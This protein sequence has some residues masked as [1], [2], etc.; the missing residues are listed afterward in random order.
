MRFWKLQSI[1]NDFP[2]IHIADAGTLDLG[3]VAIKICD[4]RFGAGGDGLLAVAMEDGDVRLRMFNP[5]G[6]E[7]FCGNGLR[8]AARHVVDQGWVGTT[9]N[10]RHLDRVVPTTVDGSRISTTIGKASYKPEDVPHLFVG[11]AFS[12]TIWSGMIDG[13]PLSLFGSALTTGSTHT[14][15]PTTVLPDDESFFS[16]APR[17]ERDEH[18]QQRTSVIWSREI[19][20]MVLEIRIWER[21]VGETLGCGTG[22]SAAAVDY[23]RRRGADSPIEGGYRVEVRNPGGTVFVRTAVWSGDLTIEGEAFAV[24]EGDWPVVVPPVP[25][26]TDATQ[27]TS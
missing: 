8:C 11:E 2:L 19:A 3:E 14:I 13:M 4:R 21:G 6:T 23:L 12:R 7:D 9:F 1:G 24:Y 18:F 20:P 27:A 25:A 16:V 15:I 22:S 5:D 26:A 10:L 17:I